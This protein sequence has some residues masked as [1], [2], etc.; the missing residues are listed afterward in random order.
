MAFAE[1]RWV[2]VC[3]VGI[4]DTLQDEF[5]EP[6]PEPEEESKSE[7]KSESE[8]ESDSES[9]PESESEAEPVQEQEANN[10]SVIIKL[11]SCCICKDKCSTYINPWFADN[12][13]HT[14]CRNC[15]YFLGENK[16]F[17]ASLTVWNCENAEKCKEMF[18]N[19]SIR[20]NK[21]K[22]T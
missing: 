17:D 2:G 5:L 7:S 13:R 3:E 1:S 20:Q 10:E 8:S 21:K 9:E 12:K 22:V 18:N 19:H 15:I 14:L 4:V 16:L 6:E 11:S